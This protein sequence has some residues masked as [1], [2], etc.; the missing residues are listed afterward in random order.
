[1]N[2]K[3]LVNAA[4]SYWR[5][6]DKKQRI[7][8]AM[9]AAVCLVCFSV[10]MW[11]AFHEDYV[12]VFHD[13][14]AQ[15]AGL[16]LDELERIDIKAKLVEAGTG[17]AVPAESADKARISIAQAN[18]PRSGTV[19]YEIL[20]NM[21]LTMTESERRIYIQRALQGELE[22]T[23]LTMP[24]VASARVHLSIPEKT[25]FIGEKGIARA[26]VVVGL[27]PGKT[28]TPGQVQ[29]IVQLLAH[30]VDGLMPENIVVMDDGGNILNLSNSLNS[31]QAGGQVQE[32]MAIEGRFEK[33]LE[34][35]VLKL[36]APLFGVNGVRISVNAELDFN[37]VKQDERL[38]LPVDE[39]KGQGIV[40][41]IV[42]LEKYFE[43][44]DG[45]GS[46]GV[47]PN[48]PNIYQGNTS[49]G[50]SIEELH[51][52][53]IEYEINEVVKSLEVAPGTVKSLSVAVVIDREEL[54]DEE[55]SALKELVTAAVGGGSQRQDNIVIS[56]MPFSSMVSEADQ[57]LPGPAARGWWAG[58]TNAVSSPI[59]L[60]FLVAV[61]AAFVVWQ[62]ARRRAQPVQ[63]IALTEEELEEAQAQAAAA[64]LEQ[65]PSKS[66]HQQ[67]V[68]RLR[69]MARQQPEEFAQLIKTLLAQDRR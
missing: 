26:S 23:L 4:I 47:D 1:M 42:E 17:I 29:G 44:E 25:P 63:E 12:T 45:S 13:L 21:S 32:Q 37:R 51:E 7:R 8:L 43:S 52:K 2:P 5:K 69:T 58:L 11:V 30:A 27:Q 34:Q 46:P 59:A 66:P 38:F 50:T 28:L 22:R 18:L 56:A 16:I 31:Y 64:L 39:E 24:S 14:D 40:R 9:V 10:L 62:V 55:V 35:N 49:G 15:D 48:D 6:S 65:E 19:G 54:S 20:N 60:G 3:Q 41:K 53:S 67:L 36:L 68:E 57:A 33:E 61:I